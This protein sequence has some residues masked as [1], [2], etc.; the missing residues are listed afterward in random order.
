MPISSPGIG[1]GLDV[2]TIVDALVKA[3]ITSVQ[4]RHDDKDKQVKTELSAVGQLKSSLA[5]FKDTL[6][7]ISDI[8]KFYSKQV[9]LSDT[10]ILSAT[11]APEALNGTYQIQVQNLAQQQTLATGYFTNNT[12]SIGASGPMTI[13]FGTYSTDINYIY[14]KSR[15][16]FC[17]IQIAPENNSL[18]AV[19][20]A[21]N[22]ADSGVVAS[23]VQDNQGSRL[24]LQSA[25]TGTNYSMQISGDITP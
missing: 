22:N 11:L 20:D 10:S 1:S 19:C 7:N 14:S 13:N 8:N 16:L 4:K 2:K 15:C 21:I 24:T 25:Q 5:S 3:E 23:I 18:S 9:T 12:T 6:N 17:S